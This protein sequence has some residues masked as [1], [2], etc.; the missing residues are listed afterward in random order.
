MLRAGQM[1]AQLPTM[2]G[3]PIDH[4]K[5]FNGASLLDAGTCQ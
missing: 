3:E 1:V 5:S 4:P 2:A